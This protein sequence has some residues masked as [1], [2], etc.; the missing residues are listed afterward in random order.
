MRYY[1]LKLQCRLCPC[2]SCFNS[3]NLIILLS[4]DL[5]YSLYFNIFC[6]VT[7]PQPFTGKLSLNNRLENVEIWHKG[8]FLGPE[9]FADLKGEL[10]TSLQTG[11]IV[12]LTGT[13]YLR[14]S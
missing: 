6:R 5:Q 14:T 9:S 7:P 8:D 12:K 4:S 1:S 11:D 13:T 10:Y 3:Y 2:I